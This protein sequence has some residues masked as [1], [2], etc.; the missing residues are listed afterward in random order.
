MEIEVD[1][2]RIVNK[3]KRNNLFL[4]KPSLE[5]VTDHLRSINN[6]HKRLDEIIKKM[7]EMVIMDQQ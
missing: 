2:E 6:P 7:N 4:N 5:M 3:F 1:R